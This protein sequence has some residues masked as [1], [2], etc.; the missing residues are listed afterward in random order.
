[1]KANAAAA[2]P[3]TPMTIPTMPRV[4]A[5]ES[6]AAAVLAAATVPPLVPGAAAGALL[7]AAVSA[8]VL[9]RVSTGAGWS[10]S[11]YPAWVRSIQRT[12]SPLE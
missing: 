12:I 10:G 2:R 3:R 11:G 4:R 1:M 5:V 7:V 9:V 6:L 8:A